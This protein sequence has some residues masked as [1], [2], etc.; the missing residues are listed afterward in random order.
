MLG[1]Y[2]WGG[3]QFGCLE[4]LWQRESGWKHTAANP[5]SGA[6]GIP[7]ALPASKM[8]SAGADWRTNPVTQIMW[9]LDYISGRYGSPC[10]AWSYW[11]AHYSY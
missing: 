8:A 4:E 10:G 1:E 5:S 11:L 2:G 9:G 7:Q 6:F 3:D